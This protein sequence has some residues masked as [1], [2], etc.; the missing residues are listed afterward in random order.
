MIGS[1]SCRDHP[2]FPIPILGAHLAYLPLSDLGHSGEPYR[3]W[4]ARF[5]T[6]RQAD[7]SKR[8]EVD[9]L[10]VRSSVSAQRRK[11][12]AALCLP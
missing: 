6:A 1:T 10:G 8:C 11:A 9:G 5:A 2:I 3:S 7:E 4:N 12:Y